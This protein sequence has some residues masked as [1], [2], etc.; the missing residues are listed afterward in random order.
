MTKK[1]TKLRMETTGNSPVFL[2]FREYDFIPERNDV[3]FYKGINYKVKY[4]KFIY[5]VGNDDLSEIILK[6]EE[7]DKKLKI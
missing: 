7:I 6:L 5:N 4:R 1:P 2:G 3:V